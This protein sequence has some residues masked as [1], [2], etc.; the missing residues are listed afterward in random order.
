[1]K[2]KSV[3]FI[4]SRG[5]SAEKGA[6]STFEFFVLEEVL[7]HLDMD[8]T[9]THDQS[10]LIANIFNN[11]KDLSASLHVN[12]PLSNKTPTDIAKFLKSHK[13]RKHQFNLLVKDVR[14]T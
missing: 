1:M 3:D 12:L 14:K 7:R 9:I 13:E 2:I 5:Q 8:H 4:Q 11:I 6:W 10:H